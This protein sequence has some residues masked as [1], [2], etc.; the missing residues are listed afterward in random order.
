MN[1]QKYWQEYLNKIKA[2]VTAPRL[3][4]LLALEQAKKPISAEELI[5]KTKLDKATVYRVLAFLSQKGVI[6]L[7]DL[8]QDK[9]LYE[10]GRHCDHHHVICN[11]CGKIKAIDICVFQ[12]ISQQ[13][14]K[15]SGF[16]KIHD[17]SM[18]FF[19]LCSQCAKNK[20]TY[21]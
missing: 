7:I 6:R 1:K 17:H 13:V 8:R 18:E 21:N 9:R 4:L 12:D 10:L 3:S 14:L 2:K 19:G 15:L 16:N 20:K 11:T 5:A